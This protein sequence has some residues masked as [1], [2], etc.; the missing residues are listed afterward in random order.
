[1]TLG[2]YTHQHSVCPAGSGPA[3]CAGSSS[4]SSDTLRYRAVQRGGCSLV[5]LEAWAVPRPGGWS[6]PGVTPAS[7]PNPAGVG[8]A[9]AQRAPCE[10]SSRLRRRCGPDGMPTVHDRVDGPGVV[11]E[12]GH[13]GP[14]LAWECRA[15]ACRNRSAW[16]SAPHYAR[17]YGRNQSSDQAHRGCLPGA[18]TRPASMPSSGR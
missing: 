4:V 5:R 14:P 8:A 1:V 7:A 18:V 12:G 13:A 3:S 16:G 9:A 15:S 11:E 2:R 6:P 10:S 17:R